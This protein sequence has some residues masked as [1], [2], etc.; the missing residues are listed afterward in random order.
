MLA[1]VA[2]ALSAIE[3][4]HAQKFSR[5][6][7]VMFEA[8]T[9][10]DSGINLSRTQSQ[11]VS[12][13]TALART[14][15][16]AAAK[17]EWQSFLKANYRRGSAMDL[18]AIETMI[19]RDAFFSDRKLLDIG[20]RYRQSTASSVEPSGNARDAVRYEALGRELQNLSEQQSKANTDNEM[21]MMQLQAAM[22]RRSQT[23]QAG[24]NFLASLHDATKTIVGNLR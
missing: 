1:L 22:Q 15:K 24:S 6:E 12:R 3:P 17:A 2:G 20:R 10:D 13:I 16:V 21:V 7:N 18:D 4:A 11:Q 23:I 9:L 14:G 8:V 5:D 19:V